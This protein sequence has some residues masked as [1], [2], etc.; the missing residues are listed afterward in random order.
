MPKYIGV[1]QQEAEKHADKKDFVLVVRDSVFRKGIPG[2]IIISQIPAAG[3]YVKEGRTIYVTVTK[4]RAEGFLSADLPVLYGKRFEFKRKELFNNFEVYSRVKEIRYDPGPE[5]HILEAYYKGK[6][7]TNADQR[8]DDIEI[9]RGD[10][11]D[12]VLSTQ[13]GGKVDMPKLICLNLAEA[14]FLL[15]TYKLELTDLQYEEEITDEEL[16]FVLWQHPKPGESV[17]LGSSIQLKIQQSRPD[18]CD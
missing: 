15:N 8:T 5:E 10:T 3:S 16:A 9:Y 14:R 17:A 11:L 6:I 1:M 4:Y 12:F 13:S 2:G 7:I 18:N